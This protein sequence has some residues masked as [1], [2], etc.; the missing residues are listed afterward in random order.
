MN[1]FNNQVSDAL[2]K[3]INSCPL[4]SVIRLV[5]Y[6][7]SADSIIEYD[8]TDNIKIHKYKKP[9]VRKVAD[10]PT[11]IKQWLADGRYDIDWPATKAQIRTI[12]KNRGGQRNNPT[13]VNDVAIA[14]DYRFILPQSPETRIKGQTYPKYILNPETFNSSE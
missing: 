10:N 14:V 6:S 11:L 12:F 7:E 5:I 9:R 1:E 8:V 2:T 4:D 13:L 3:W